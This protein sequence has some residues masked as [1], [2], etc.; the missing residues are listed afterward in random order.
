MTRTKLLALGLGL[1]VLFAACGDDDDD[2]STSTTATPSESSAP[3][4]AEPEPTDA[5]TTTV[6]ADT[7]VAGPG[8]WDG[9]AEAAVA[10]VQG[11]L[12]GVHAGA[13]YYGSITGV[14]VDPTYGVGTIETTLTDAAAAVSA[15]TDAAMV[16]W[17]D[18]ANLLGLDVT[19]GNGNVLALGSAASACVAA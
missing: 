2:S 3:D 5:A 14:S 6:A 4:V 18:P 15:C 16:A 17:G 7:T 12:D 10:A 19:D 1:T 13:A 9:D 11:H 8:A